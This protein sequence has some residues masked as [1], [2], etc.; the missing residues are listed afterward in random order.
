M[1]LVA[2]GS[3][4]VDIVVSGMPAELARGDKQEVGSIDLYPGGGALNATASFMEQGESVRLLGALGRDGLGERLRSH[5]EQLGV[6]VS[7][8]QICPDQ[9]TGKAIVLV[10]PSGS[11]SVLARRGANACLR[12][13]AQDLQADLIYVAPL[14]LQPM[15]SVAQAL[16]ERSDTS[17][18]L[19]VNP[20]VACLQHQGQGFKQVYARADVLGLNAVEAQMLAGVQDADIQ[21]ELS[22][23]EACELAAR[24]QHHP[25]QAL[26]ITL[27]V[28]GAVLAFNGQQYVEPACKVEVCSTVGAGDAFLSSFAL[29]WKRGLEPTEALKLA[30]QAAAARLGQWAANTFPPMFGQDA[31]QALTL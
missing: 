28:Q 12:V 5:I 27:G 10:E 13:Q 2:I 29:A 18:C 1:Q 3:I 23:Q 14:A 6:D 7:S 17:A 15:E 21:L 31:A 25:Q 8:M 4:T 19:V 22:I 9:P 11:A 20:S 24:L 26:L 30:S 16:A